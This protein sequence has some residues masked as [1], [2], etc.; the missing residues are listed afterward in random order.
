MRRLA[1]FFVLV[2]IFSIALPIAAFG[3]PGDHGVSDNS[4]N[5]STVNQGS[6]VQNPINQ[7]S[8]N[9]GNTD[10]NNDLKKCTEFIPPDEQNPNLTP[11]EKQAAEQSRRQFE[12]NFVCEEQ[13]DHYQKWVSKDGKIVSF[14][15]TNPLDTARYWAQNLWNNPNF[16]EEFKPFP[17]HVGGELITDP[18]DPRFNGPQPDGPPGKIEPDPR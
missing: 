17:G 8:I 7:N 13:G 2:F 3:A 14:I 15:W 1:Q 9:Q 5:Q 11:E 18:N 16:F 12:Q 10:Q 6:V 4:G